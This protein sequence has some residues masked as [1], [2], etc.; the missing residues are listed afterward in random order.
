MIDSV[1]GKRHLEATQTSTQNKKQKL[2]GK[3]TVLLLRA[4]L[5]VPDAVSYNNPEGQSDTQTDLYK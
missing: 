4:C 2:K 3:Y 5:Q 1:W